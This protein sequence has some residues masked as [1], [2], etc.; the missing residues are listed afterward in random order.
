MQEDLLMQLSNQSSLSEIQDYIKN[1]IKLRNLED[2]NIQEVTLLLLE[3]VGELA[4]ALR[5]KLPNSK[6]DK[7]KLNHYTAIEEEIADVFIV[8]NVLCNI[9]NIDLYTAF[10]D[11]EKIN[12][13]RKWNEC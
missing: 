1:V 7:T 5:K 12:V 6:I 3:E 8:L 11:K 9:L 13:N 10:I 2:R 4:K